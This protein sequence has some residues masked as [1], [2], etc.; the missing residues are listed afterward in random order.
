MPA[1][2]GSHLRRLALYRDC[3]GLVLPLSLEGA[4]WVLGPAGRP[5]PGA[6]GQGWAHAGEP[7][8]SSWVGGQMFGFLC[9][10]LRPGC[11]EM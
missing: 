11:D 6:S 7:G 8:A 10:D 3:F 1:A 5:P 9:A 4:G 2:A